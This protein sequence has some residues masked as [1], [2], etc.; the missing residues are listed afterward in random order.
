ME[1][2]N[3]S[4][5]TPAPTAKNAWKPKKSPW[6][7]LSIVIL[8][9]LALLSGAV[10]L[11]VHPEYEDAIMS[12]KRTE[13]NFAMEVVKKAPKLATQFPV[14]DVI[15]Y[16][17]AKGDASLSQKVIFSGY[18]VDIK[19][20]GACARV[21]FPDGPEK[22]LPLKNVCFQQKEVVKYDFSF[23]SNTWKDVSSWTVSAWDK[24]GLSKIGEFYSNS[25]SGL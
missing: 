5:K 23:L 16:K 2:K 8:M 21:Q 7:V 14:S 13:Q 17:T 24:I 3:A 12:K 20:G 25:L 22:A 18:F 9:I 6:P 19:S 10:F 15:H 4:F 11:A 1:T